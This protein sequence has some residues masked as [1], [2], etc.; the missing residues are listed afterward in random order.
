MTDARR[1][2]KGE[3]GITVPA[4]GIAAGARIALRMAQTL[5]FGKSGRPL[6]EW[7]AV[8]IAMTAVDLLAI[9]PCLLGRDALYGRL[10]AGKALSGADL[11]RYW[12]AGEYK[13]ALAWRLGM[14]RRRLTAYGL[15]WLPGTALWA[16]GTRTRLAAVHRGETDFL[17]F[18]FFAAGALALAA[19][20]MAAALWMLRWRPAAW[21]IG[22]GASPREAFAQSR[23]ITRGRTG[24]LV[25]FYRGQTGWL[26]AGAAALPGLYARPVR[27]MREATLFQKW[28]AALEKTK[29]MC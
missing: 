8:V 23:R 13:R 14:W 17:A 2:L 4:E 29:R 5:A 20:T 21:L 7:L 15:G 3:W 11:R 25:R 28:A 24:E 18:G 1:R 26:L 22:R 19:G 10:T 27:R 9:S 16:I 6:G 12:R